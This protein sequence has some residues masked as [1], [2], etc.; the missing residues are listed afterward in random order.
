MLAN[1]TPERWFD[2]TAFPV[3]P[4][5]SF[6]FGSSG[7]NILDGPGSMVVNVSLLKNARMR[8][9]HRVQFRWEVFNALNRANFGLPIATVNT[10]TAGTISSA[11][12]AR[13]MQFGLRYQF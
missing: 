9:R 7:R 12:A 6:R 11:G 10:V 4:N 5:N 2:L 1:P 3:V 8:E 13:Q